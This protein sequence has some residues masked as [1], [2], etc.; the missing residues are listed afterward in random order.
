[1]PFLVRGLVM[2]PLMNPFLLPI[3]INTKEANRFYF[4]LLGSETTQ[5]K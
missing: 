1:M 5:N 2:L 3:N 4:S